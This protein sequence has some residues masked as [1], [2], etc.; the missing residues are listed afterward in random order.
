MGV[1][2][3]GELTLESN[4]TIEGNPT[5]MMIEGDRLVISSSIY[6]WSLPEDSE[7]RKLM[8]EE[9]TATDPFSDVTYSYTKVQ[10]LVKYTVVD[11]T[12]RS[13]PVVEKEMYIEGNYHT[14]RMVDGTVR[15]VTHL[16]HTSTESETGSNYQRSTGQ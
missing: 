8:S 2:E 7:L 15:S 9:V 16:G 5:Q 6:Y 12:D 14:A 10:N 1:P 3:F 11:I 13:S 4:L